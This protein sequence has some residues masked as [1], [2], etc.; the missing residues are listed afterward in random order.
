M[1]YSM[2]MKSKSKD[3]SGN[4]VSATMEMTRI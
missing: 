1:P 4:D 2:T 3:P